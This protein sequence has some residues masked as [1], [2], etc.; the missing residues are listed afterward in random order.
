MLLNRDYQIQAYQLQK[1]EFVH[2][3]QYRGAWLQLLLAIYQ[4]NKHSYMVLFQY[5]D[6]IIPVSQVK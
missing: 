2:K 1:P 3:L 5:H 6:K 4:V